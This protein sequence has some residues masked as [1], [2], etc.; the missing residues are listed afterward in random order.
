MLTII[1]AKSQITVIT[2]QVLSSDK[3]EFPGVFV[4]Q[5]DTD[6][7]TIWDFDGNFSI[8]VLDSGG[9]VDLRFLHINNLEWLFKNIPLSKDTIKLSQ[10]FL[11]DCKFVTTEEYEKLNKLEKDKC[12]LEEICG[13]FIYFYCNF[14]GEFFEIACPSDKSIINRFEYDVENKRMVIDYKDFKIC[15]W[16]KSIVIAY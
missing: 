5:K 16:S 4:I 1:V 13:S 6:N 10:I 9:L 7:G 15:P 14:E 8:E 2:G 11:K 12:S 3:N